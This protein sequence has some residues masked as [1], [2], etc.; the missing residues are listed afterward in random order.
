MTPGPGQ[1]LLRVSACGICHSEMKPYLT[2][3]ADGGS[4][5]LLGHEVVGQVVE[6]GIGVDE[7]A[8]GDRVSGLLGQG[9]ATHALANSGQLLRLPDGLSDGQ[10]LLEP[11]KCVVTAARGA[12]FEF[13]DSVALVGCG[14]MG[15]LVLAC[16][17]WRGARHLIG[18]DL[19]PDRLAL[20]RELGATDVIDAR[21]GPA[22]VVAAV[23]ELTG[24]RMVDVAIEA[25]GS[26]PALELACLVLRRVRPKLVMVGYHNRPQQI[27]M[28]NFAARGLIMHVTHPAYSEDQTED[29]R[30]ALWALERGIM[31]AERLVTHRYRLDEI[32]A[33]FEAALTPRDG[34][35]KGIVLP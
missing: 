15:L 28:T 2:G 18:I 1:V 6:V 14:Y 21:P 34:Y 3:P 16:L 8:V 13:G 4:P 30:R 24:G 32:Q 35:I 22:A 7:L 29:L 26:A 27:D 17:R 25:A 23:N 31:P 20:A 5:L 10:A 12:G 11:A 33:G 19:D 9:F